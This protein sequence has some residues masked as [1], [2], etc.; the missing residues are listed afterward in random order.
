[1]SS[2]AIGSLGSPL[3]PPTAPHVRLVVQGEGESSK[4]IECRHVATLIGSRSGCKVQLHHETVSPVHAVIVC[5]GES[6]HGV[7]LV[8]QN[9]T[10]LNNL[11]MELESITN[12]DM[13]EIFPFEFRVDVENPSHH[14]VGADGLTTLEP[15]P[16][17]VA[18]EL[19]GVGR[20]LRPARCVCL[21]GRRDGC[22]IVLQDKK[23]SRAHALLMH[24]QGHPAIV[25]LLSAHGTMVNGTPVAF[26]M[27]RDGDIVRIGDTELKVHVV[28][29][30]VARAA[31]NGNG[32][33]KNNGTASAVMAKALVEKSSGPDM[34]DIAT[35]E[36]AERWAIADSAR[37]IAKKN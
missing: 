20:L 3:L 24:Y 2:S 15:S 36:G 14:G 13:L 1:M 6:V 17:M 33:A 26:H 10:R 12:G 11:K 27:L 16:E 8:S 5:D 29:S 25:D 28:E 9:G 32:Y 35:V 18:L 37:K 23:A 7:D 22:D 30:A 31:K 19:V 4:T 21:I 34:V